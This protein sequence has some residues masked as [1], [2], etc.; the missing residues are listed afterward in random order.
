MRSAVYTALAISIACIRVGSATPVAAEPAPDS[1]GDGIPDALDKCAHDPRNVAP[2]DCDTD[3]DGYGNVCDA[4][5]DQSGSTTSVDFTEYFVP[6]FKTG[7][8][9]PRGTDMN[10]DGR[11][12]AAD[13]DRYF[14]PAFMRGET[15]SQSGL[16]C[17]G[18]PG[19]G[20]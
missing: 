13:F 20:C 5:F 6:S 17:A 19:C 10:C 14:L 16:A 1:D 8:P 18:Q 4:D 9:S 3:C 2:R 12:S 7:T 15:E 11:V